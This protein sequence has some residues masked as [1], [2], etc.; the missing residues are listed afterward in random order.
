MNNMSSGEV[1]EDGLKN[2]Y[3]AYALGMWFALFSL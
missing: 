3:D 1:T 2:A